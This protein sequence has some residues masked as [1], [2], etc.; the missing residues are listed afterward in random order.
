[1]MLW[2]LNHPERLS[3]EREEIARL[4]RSAKWLLGAEWKLDDGLCLDAVIRAHDHDYEVRVSFP[5][6]YPDVPATVRPR[7]RQDRISAHQYGGADGPLCLEWGPD[8]W[9]RGITAVQMLESAYKLFETENPL[10][11]NRPAVPITAPSR[12]ALTVGQELRCEWAWWF[13][14]AGL[15]EFLATQS[16]NSV[17]QFKFSF[18]NK[19]KNWH[20]L[21]HEAAIIGGTSWKDLEV[22][23]CLSGASDILNVGVWFKTDLAAET[24]GEPK[25]LA[26]LQQLLASVRGAKFLA[27]DGTSPISEFNRPIA[28]VIVIDRTGAVHFFVIL[29]SET[30]YRCVKVSAERVPIE[31]RAPDAAAL[32][33]KVIGIVGLGSAGSKIALSLARMGVRKFYLVDHDIL[34]PQNLRRHA[35]DWQ[36]VLDHKVSAVAAALKQ[37]SGSIEVDVSQLHLTGQ[38]STAAVGGALDR[39][40]RC[41]LIVDA[42]ADSRVFNLLAATVRTAVKPMVWLEIYGGGIGGMVARSRPNIDPVPQDM[43]AVFLQYCVENPGPTVGKN[44]VDYAIESDDGKVI[45]ASDADVTIIAHHAARFVS[46]SFVSPES[47]QFPYSM[48]LIGLAKGWVFEAPFATIPISMLSKN[49]S[50][51]KSGTDSEF[52][53]D[54]VEFILGLLKP[55]NA[56]VNSADNN[57]STG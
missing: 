56:V 20:I 11:S 2:F 24:I 44:P 26:D 54:N 33:G 35:L 28:A 19:R 14:S 5:T 51:W 52:K 6:L 46:D 1:M 16:V 3:Q 55:Q 36:S 32:N 30:A 9:H 43:R 37:I 40:A 41:D 31:T 50:G 34:L 21:V 8:N 39:L 29:S 42:T 48:Y 12:H 57:V 4:S 13:E 49:V 10:G 45:I 17:G 27:T 53:A 7:N 18:R 22:P 47:S 38:E 15:A 23:S 25:N